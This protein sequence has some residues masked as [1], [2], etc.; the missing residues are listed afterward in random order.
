MTIRSLNIAQ[1]GEKFMTFIIFSIEPRMLA[2]R[3]LMGKLV[4]LVGIELDDRGSDWRCPHLVE[5]DK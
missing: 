1:K 3:E 4:E 2:E 5:Q